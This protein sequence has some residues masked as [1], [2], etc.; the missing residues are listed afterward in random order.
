MADFNLGTVTAYGYAKDKGYTGTEDE[1]AEL[2][3]SY[4]QVAE[5]AAESAEQAAQSATTA[6]TK[7]GE[8]ATSATN[9]A[10]ANTAAQAAKTGAETAAQTATTKADEAS[11]SAATATTKAA[12]ASTSATNAAQSATTATTKAG[13]ATTSATNAAASASA[14]AGSAQTAQDVADSIPADYSQMSEDVSQLKED[15]V[16]KDGYHEVMPENISGVSINGNIFADAELSAT[17]KYVNVSNGKLVYTTLNNFNSYIIKAYPVKYSFTFAR[18]AL[19]LEDDK[20]TA[21]GSLIQNTELIDNTNGNAKYIAFSFNVSSYPVSSYVVSIGETLDPSDK[22]YVLP[23]WMIYKDTKPKSSRIKGNLN[24]NGSLVITATTAKETTTNL[25]KGERIAFSANIT[26]FSGVEVGLS[27]NN[28][29]GDARINRVSV[30]ESDVAV[31]TLGTAASAVTV[32]HGL[33]ITNN[34]QII[35]EQLP[36]RQM[37]LSVVSNGN[38]FTQTF[39]WSKDAYGMPYA[40]S[41]GSTL[42]DCELSWT[43]TDLE[44][45]IWIFGDSYLQYQSVRWTYYLHEAG[46]DENVLLD[47]YAGEASGAGRAALR[48]LLNYSTPKYVVWILGMNDGSDTDNTTP[49][50]SWVSKR[51]DIIQMCDANNITLVF[52]TIPTVPSVNNNA[53]NAWIRSSGYRY[54][55]FAKSVGADETGAWYSGMLSSDRVHPS[56]AGAMA[57]Y[58]QAIT[59]MPEIMIDN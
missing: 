13:E 51:D 48:S 37:K 10:N 4:A 22:A 35:L 43:C 38:R 41:N 58:M 19:M 6:T 46:Y 33:T 28:A 24:S 29:L 39:A 5:D 9:A 3:A 50:A 15:I 23:D 42:T 54:I 21:V 44:K 14:A 18:F 53:K 2:M 7:A 32:Q 59:D 57:L 40:L 55:D 56:E 20:E 49:N 25:R 12:E 1:F 17:N 16:N 26:S 52:G 30:N 27:Y 8:A 47:G 34:I 11:G 36:T 45:N 31:Y